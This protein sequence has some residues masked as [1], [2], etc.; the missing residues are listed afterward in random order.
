MEK[1]QLLHKWLNNEATAEEIER[2]KSDPKYASYL[3]IADAASGFGIPEMNEGANFDAIS[4]KIQPVRQLEK[5][6]VFSIVWKVA[7]IFAL[8]LAGYYYT[9]TLDTSIKTEIATTETFLLPDNSEVILNAGSQITYNKKDWS[10]TRTLSLDGEAYFKVT[11]GNK[12]SVNT[13]EGIVSVLGTQFNVSARDGVFKV[14]CYEGLVSV[15]FN[16]TLLK[17]AAGETVEIENG[18]IVTSGATE[19]TAPV[20]LNEES[21]FE[22]APLQRVVKELERHYPINV[23]IQNVDAKKRFTGSFTHKNLELA[24]K[25]ICEPLQLDYKINDN[26]AVTIDNKNSK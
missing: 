24:L 26:G 12:F 19:N 16:D 3:Q 20:W 15:A 4:K 2:L 25:S 21:S 11:K 9:T 8:L 6:K 17:L 1:D 10:K 5:P 14:A 7:A 13:S 23:S 18:E 22:N